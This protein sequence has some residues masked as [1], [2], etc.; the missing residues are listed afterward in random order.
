MSLSPLRRV[1]SW[2]S[3][4]SRDR[5]ILTLLGIL[6]VG[7]YLRLWNIHHLFNAI[8][9]YDEGVYSL[10]ARFISQGY[11]PYQDFI[12]AHPPLHSLTL[13]SI[14]SVVGYDFF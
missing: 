14:Y 7:A 8:H 2:L 5:K 6:G 9:D 3:K 11:L 10:G 1:L 13:A 12:L 4:V